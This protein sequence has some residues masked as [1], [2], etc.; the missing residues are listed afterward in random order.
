MIFMML[1]GFDAKDCSIRL[2]NAG[3]FNF[4]FPPR[5]LSVIFP[6]WVLVM[7]RVPG[8]L[9]ARQRD[10]FRFV[11]ET[12]A[13]KSGDVLVRDTPG[14][15]WNEGTVVKPPVATVNGPG[16]RKLI[17][18]AKASNCA[19]TL[20][21]SFLI[22]KK[23]PTDS[24]HVEVTSNPELDAG[25]PDQSRDFDFVVRAVADKFDQAQVTDL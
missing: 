19:D 11:L 16:I 15:H 25:N 23:I 2:Y 9:N 21:E 6:N 18:G 10:A 22:A 24:N 12:T 14:D 1:K 4:P 5:D 20:A 3:L 7:S 17:S 8:P 13:E